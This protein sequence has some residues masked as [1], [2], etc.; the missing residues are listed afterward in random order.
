MLLNIKYIIK[1]ISFIFIIKF[2]LYIKNN[3]I[4]YNIILIIINYF[5]KTLFF[6]FT[7]KIFNIVKLIYILYK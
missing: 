1:L 6:I 2:Q 5:I 3:S 7:I 4:I